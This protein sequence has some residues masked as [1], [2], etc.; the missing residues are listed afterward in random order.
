MVPKAG[1]KLATDRVR[2]IHLVD[3]LVH[4]WDLANALGRDSDI[5]PGLPRHRILTVSSD[6]PI[7]PG[8]PKLQG[9]GRSTNWWRC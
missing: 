6:S 8:H 2:A 5:D 9:A 1:A 3:M 7:A 4:R